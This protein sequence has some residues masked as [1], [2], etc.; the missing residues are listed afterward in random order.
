MKN[1]IF[2]F[3]KTTLLATACAALTN[4]TAQAG[5]PEAGARIYGSIAVNGAVVTSADSVIVIEARR[6]PT[7]PPIASYRMGSITNAGN[8]YS[9]KVNAEVAPVTGTNN[10]AIGSSIYLVVR[11][12]VSDLDQKAFTLSARGISARVDFGAVDTDGDGMSDAFEQ[13]HFGSAT[14]GN[15]NGDDDGDGRPNLR[16]FLQGTNP[17]VADGRHPADLSPADDR[18]SLKEVTDYIL[19]WKTGGTWPIEPALNSPNI[20]DYVTRAGAIWKGGEVYV[21]DND[22]VTVAP[23]W[24][25]NAPVAGDLSKGKVE[26]PLI[27]A[28]T[29][30]EVTVGRSITSTYAPNQPIPVNLTVTPGKT[31]KAYAVVEA[32]PTGWTVRNLSHEG[33]WDANNRRIKW[34]PFF[35]QTPRILTYEAVPGPSSN[36]AADFAGRGSFDG[37]GKVA[38]GPLRVWPAGTSPQPSLVFSAPG[39]HGHSV[40][41]HGEA[42]RRYELLFSNDLQEWLPG[43]TV[44]LDSQGRALMPV[45]DEHATYFVRVRTVE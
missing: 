10:V 23:L 15:A 3:A 22:P 40:E 6:T 16:E 14:G 5:L 4:L 17:N 42:G 28:D 21:F 45:D 34:G 19:A 38:D 7:G 13:T 41:L 25:T 43:P 30:S 37:V 33:R 36:G 44:S 2:Q 32:P 39:G 1:P 12:G 9:L 27:A 26:A 8:F 20:E 29:S 11:D 35:D 24:W 31:T 18:I